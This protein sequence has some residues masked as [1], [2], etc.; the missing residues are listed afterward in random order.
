[1]IHSPVD[2]KSLGFR[3]T[4]LYVCSRQDRREES[5][6]NCR[7][8]PPA[9][10]GRRANLPIVSEKDFFRNDCTSDR[11]EFCDIMGKI[12][13]GMPQFRRLQT[14]E[15]YGKEKRRKGEKI[16]MSEKEKDKLRPMTA[17]RI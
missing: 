9:D 10:A 11:E 14:A 17:V 12:E 5:R 7:Y 6:N 8:L 2:G 3:F 13:I 15:I 16:G 1:M 4:G